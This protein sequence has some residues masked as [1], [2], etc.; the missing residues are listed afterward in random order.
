M[1]EA[2]KIVPAFKAAVAV[3][4][5][6]KLESFEAN[7]CP[8]RQKFPRLGERGEFG[9]VALKCR[10]PIRRRA[11]RRGLRGKFAKRGLLHQA[12]PML[13]RAPPG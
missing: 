3:L 8:H 13:R 7:G 6:A 10:E 5:E 11:A 2:L 9:V 12:I 4:V 1:N